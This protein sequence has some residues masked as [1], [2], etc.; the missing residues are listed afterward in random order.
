MVEFNLFFVEKVSS[1]FTRGTRE[2]LFLCIPLPYIRYL[3]LNWGVLEKNEE[4][5]YDYLI[6]TVTC[7]LF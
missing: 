4:R 5:W 2:L 6:S 1:N 7:L 3:V